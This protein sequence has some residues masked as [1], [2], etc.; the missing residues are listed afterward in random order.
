M[1]RTKQY[2]GCRRR[3]FVRLLQ[4]DNYSREMQAKFRWDRRVA[5]DKERAYLKNIAY[6]AVAPSNLRKQVAQRDA[7]KS[8]SSDSLPSS[9]LAAP[10]KPVVFTEHHRIVEGELLVL[11]ANGL[12]PF[13][14]PMQNDSLGS[15][16]KSRYSDSR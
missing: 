14:K 12:L 16:E 4:E 10:P 13:W 6:V 5:E 11:S 15:E 2:D 3:G 7:G 9:S 1:G 8:S